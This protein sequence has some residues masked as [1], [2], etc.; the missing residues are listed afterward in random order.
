MICFQTTDASM[1]FVIVYGHTPDPAP[2]PVLMSTPWSVQGRDSGQA[3]LNYGSFW[4]DIWQVPLEDDLLSVRDGEVSTP[5]S[6][7]GLPSR[8]VVVATPMA[9]SRDPFALTV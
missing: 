6:V 7:Q 2:V 9:L 1:A 8:E 4:H 3:Y 5:W